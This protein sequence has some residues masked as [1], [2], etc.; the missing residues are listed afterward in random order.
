[1][2]EHFTFRQ[3]VIGKYD[4]D[5][6]EL[7][8]DSFDCMPLSALVDDKYLLTHGGISPDLIKVNIATNKTSQS[9]SIKS[10]DFKKLL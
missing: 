8:I 9:K 5:M 3:E 1:M 7:I 2:T 4:E 10:K 6:Y